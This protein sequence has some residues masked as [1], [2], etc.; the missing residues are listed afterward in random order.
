MISFC[1]LRLSPGTAPSTRFKLVVRCMKI[2]RERKRAQ[3]RKRERGEIPK[4]GRLEERDGEEEAE[5]G[6]CEHHKATR[7]QLRPSFCFI[8]LRF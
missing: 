7:S 1:T 3:Y 2:V 8:S 4:E 5:C 6:L